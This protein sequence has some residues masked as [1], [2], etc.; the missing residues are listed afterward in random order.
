[1]TPNRFGLPPPSPSPEN[2]EARAK[3]QAEVTARLEKAFAAAVDQ[4]G[5]DDARRVWGQVSSSHKRRRGKPRKRE[6]SILDRWF[7]IFWEDWMKDDPN[8]KTVITVLAGVL[9]KH[10]PK[11]FMHIQRE[12]LER[13]I[14]KL[15]KDLK[16]GRI[17]RDGDDFKMAPRSRGN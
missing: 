15:V 14:R 7:L 16:E 10:A 12:S 2:E 8:S 1:M 5:L 3:R 13:Y 6:L 17:I 11:L 4:L 9:H